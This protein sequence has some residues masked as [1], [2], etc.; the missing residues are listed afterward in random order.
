M[1]MFPWKS[2]FL[3]ADLKTPLPRRLNF[4]SPDKIIELV[5]R[6]GGFRRTIH[7]AYPTTDQVGQT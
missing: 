1:G 3:E 4:V 5:E 2:Q 6:G 7:E